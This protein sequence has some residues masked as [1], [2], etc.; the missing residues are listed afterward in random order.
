MAVYFADNPPSGTLVAG[1]PGRILR[2][3]R[4]L[5]SS[6]QNGFF[7]LRHSSGSGEEAN[8]TPRFYVR[9]A[10]MSPL[11]IAF[12]GEAPQTPAGR[13]LG[14]YTELAGNYSI[15]LEYELVT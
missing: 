4:V 5:F 15:W 13:S 3:R 11:D 6:D 14:F 2:V 12:R 1:T 8:I 7:E 9:A 10:G